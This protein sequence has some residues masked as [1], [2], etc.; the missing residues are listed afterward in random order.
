MLSVDSLL[1]K[2]LVNTGQNT[3]TKT[4]VSSKGTFDTYI[5]GD[6]DKSIEEDDDLNAP[7]KDKS[8]DIKKNVNDADILSLIVPY[9][10]D[11]IIKE[12]IKEVS[13]DG[14]LI[15]STVDVTESVL[16]VIDNVLNEVNLQEGVEIDKDMFTLVDDTT[17]LLNTIQKEDKTT[18]NDI[19]V[20]NSIL[21]TDDSVVNI[22]DIISTVDYVDI[23]TEDVGLVSIEE[24]VELVELPVPTLLEGVLNENISSN[25]NI[26]ENM[27]LPS[28]L[29]V[30]RED[31][32]LQD[33]LSNIHH[34]SKEGIE[35]LKL[36]LNPKDLGHMLIDI[37]K[38]TEST[39]M[40]I[41]LSDK[42]LFNLV[43]NNIEELNSY[44][45][46]I[47]LKVTEVSL[48]L[49]QNLGYGY[50]KESNSRQSNNRGNKTKKENTE[51]GIDEIVHK[52]DI[53]IIKDD[54]VILCV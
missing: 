9:T 3:T 11:T 40:V 2:T 36:K 39:K 35:H 49:N 24:G 52:R 45:G 33:M 26:T 42:E 23:I 44:I 38:T 18:N 14:V 46:K 51:K 32:L 25:M 10:T 12:D 50:E 20:L 27:E 43:Q 31:M 29:G 54:R 17:Q 7:S 6:C 22:R 41:T 4:N 48:E 5:D 34:M 1:L 19:T 8:K 16:P 53:E 37:M 15:D 13:F 21:D 47:D 28:Y 30:V